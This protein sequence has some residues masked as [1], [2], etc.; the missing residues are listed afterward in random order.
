MRVNDCVSPTAQMPH[1]LDEAEDV[2][3]RVKR[4]INAAEREHLDATRFVIGDDSGIGGK[5]SGIAAMASRHPYQRCHV[6]HD[7]AEFAASDN[8]ENFEGCHATGD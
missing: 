3:K 1:E 4:S 2:A 6:R 5:H 8:V 7:P